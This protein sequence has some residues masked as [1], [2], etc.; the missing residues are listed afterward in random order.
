MFKAIIF[1]VSGIIE[2]MKKATL[3]EKLKNKRVK[4]LACAHYCQIMPG[5]TG[6]CGV[7]LNKDGELYLLVYGKAAAVNVDPIEKK[8]L[9]HFLPGT[10]I[11]S[12]GTV[13]CNFGCDFCQN[14][15]LSQSSKIVQQKIKDPKEK[16]LKL[17][18]LV[19][20]GQ[21]LP[22]EKIVKYCLERK[23]PSLAYTYNEPVI[24]FEYIYDTAKLAHA[25]GIKNVFVSNGYESQEAMQE[26][27]PYLDAINIDLKSFSERFYQKTC[28]AHLEPV[29]KNIKR[30]YEMKIWLEVTTLVVP[31][32]NDSNKELESI[33]KFIAGVSKGIPWHV[34]AFHPEYKMNDKPATP[35]E[36]LQKAYKIGKKAGLKYIYTGNVFDL[37]HQSTYC[38]KCGQLLI[39]RDWHT[40]TESNIVNS[41]CPKCGMKIEGVWN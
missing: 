12:I 26:I 3:Y 23:I 13:G 22:P 15:D 24:F 36:S 37:E 28:K 39:G 25:Q 4:C 7:R 38:P 27:H 5:R 30:A 21:D 40:I 1:F 6:I 10:E 8:P 41:K 20:Y 9:F 31:G 32:E 2:V 19:E 35:A 14:W 11:F 16:I 17:G 18:K 33:A 34:T 29:L